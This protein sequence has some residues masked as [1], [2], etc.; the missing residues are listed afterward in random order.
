MRG[1]AANLGALQLAATCEALE[2]ALRNGSPVD[3]DLLDQVRTDSSRACDALAAM[4]AGR[5]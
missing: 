2:T 3:A 4:L 1:A 5:T